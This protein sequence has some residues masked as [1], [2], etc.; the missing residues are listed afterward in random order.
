MGS[1]NQS[2]NQHS[3]AWGHIPAIPANQETEI[4]DSQSVVNREKV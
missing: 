1:E 2:A 4:G 3:Q